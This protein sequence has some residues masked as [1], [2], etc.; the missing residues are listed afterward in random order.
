MERNDGKRNEM[1]QGLRFF[2][3]SVGVLLLLATGCKKAPAPHTDQPQDRLLF[4]WGQALASGDKQAAMAFYDLDLRQ[5]LDF[6]NKEMKPLNN[7]IKQ[8]ELLTANR[9]R[10]GEKAALE[11]VGDEAWKELGGEAWAKELAEG[12]CASGLPSPSDARPSVAPVPVKAMGQD[13]GQWAFDLQRDVAWAP[14]FRV[15]CPSG[16]SFWVQM[17]KRH[18]ATGEAVDPPLK[19]LRVVP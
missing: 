7:P 12:Q 19:L 15:S 13:L 11:T 2:M 1:T 18:R 17:V 5:R 14:A 6:W 10:L 4:D 3:G 16:A 8:L 9:A